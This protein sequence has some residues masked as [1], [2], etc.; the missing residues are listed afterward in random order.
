MSAKGKGKIDNTTL[1]ISNNKDKGIL[2]PVT[3]I[4]KIK[5][6][7]LIKIRDLTI[8]T[9]DRTKFSAYKT[10]VSLAV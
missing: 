3:T 8:F 5:K 6:N 10:F 9:K 7:T 4:V 1:V 2:T